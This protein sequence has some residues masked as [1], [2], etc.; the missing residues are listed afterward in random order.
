VVG[1][2]RT[3]LELLD[4]QW[5]RPALRLVQMHRQ[6]RKPLLT[7]P[8]LL[9]IW[10]LSQHLLPLKQQKQC[11]CNK[12]PSRVRLDLVLQLQQLLRA[13]P[14]KMLLLQQQQQLPAPPLCAV[15]WMGRRLLPLR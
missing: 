14:L 3:Q 11:S 5:L 15:E 9:W 7:R 8:K 4:E 12:A 2:S 1:P 6:Q 13:D 10:L